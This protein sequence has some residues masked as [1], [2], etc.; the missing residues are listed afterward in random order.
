[1]SQSRLTAGTSDFWIQISHSRHEPVEL[2]GRALLSGGTTV[3]TFVSSDH[4]GEE[5]EWKMG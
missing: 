4:V 2:G 5:E 3:A 1:M